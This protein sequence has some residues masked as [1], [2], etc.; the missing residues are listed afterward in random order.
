MLAGRG[1]AVGSEVVDPRRLSDVLWAYCKGPSAP[2][3]ELV[4]RSI[5]PFIEYWWSTA[6]DA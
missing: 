5:E 6:D 2:R 4:S 3:I 1:M